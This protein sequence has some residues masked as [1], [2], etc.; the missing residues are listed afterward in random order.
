MTNQKLDVLGQGVS[1]LPA[2]WVAAE[3][4]VSILCRPQLLCS[5]PVNP[6]GVMIDSGRPRSPQISSCPTPSP[7]AEPGKSVF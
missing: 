4:L 6:F 7:R 3:M 1:D 2:V 5:I